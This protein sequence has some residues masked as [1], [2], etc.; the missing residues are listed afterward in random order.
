MYCAY[1]ILHIVCLVSYIQMSE[2]SLIHLVWW[3][4]YHGRDV[5]CMVDVMSYTV[6]M[7]SYIVGVMSWIQWMFR[8]MYSDVISYTVDGMSYIVGVMSYTMDVMSHIVDDL[9]LTQWVWCH[10]YRGCDDT[11][12]VTV[13]SHVYWMRCHIQWMHYHMSPHI[14]VFDVMNTVEVFHKNCGLMS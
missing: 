6:D 4:R 10:R 1:D 9:S 8:H 14:C 11:G 13:M 2:I 3:N 7:M 5:T 12:T